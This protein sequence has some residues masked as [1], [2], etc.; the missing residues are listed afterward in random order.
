MFELCAVA[1]TIGAI[2]YRNLNMEMGTIALIA[3][4]SACFVALKIHTKRGAMFAVLL[5]SM[6]VLGALAVRHADRPISRDTFGQR[7][8]TAKILAVDRRLVQAN[9]IVRDKETGKRL[10]V[11]LRQRTTFLP[12]DTLHIHGLVE[13]PETFTTA[14]GRTF[15]YPRYLASKGIVGIGK[16][17]DAELLQ[18][19]RFSLARLAA[20]IRFRIADIFG[21]Y[22]S[23]PIDG[24]IAGMTV[25]Y[26]GGIPQSVQDLFRDTGVL[27]V[28]VLSGYNITML[29]GFLGLL[30]RGLS[31]RWRTAV[32]M[33]AII[34]LVVVSG[35]GVASVRA[36][37]MGSIALIAG[38]SI[39]RYQPFRALVLTYLLFFFL[40]PTMIFSDPGFHLSFLATAFMIVVLPKVELLFGWIPQTKV[41]NVR[42]LLMLAFSAPIFMLPYTMYF[43]GSFPLASP[44]A[45]IVL[46]IVTPICMLAAIAVLG[47]S[48]ITPLAHALGVALSLLGMVVLR[49]LT[50]SARLPVWNA[51]A[52]PWWAVLGVYGGTCGLLFRRELRQH[53]SRVRNSL[54]HASS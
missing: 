27:H 35:S 6:G 16:N 50:I 22:L 21:E 14:T 45:N 34:L 41:V 31:L 15:D 52:I 13:A 40:S 49:I 10:S 39:H 43:S 11:P 54:Q 18:E 2:L 9:L 25:G 26:Q 24:I 38:L 12:G 53:F 19:G 28:L 29:A 1:I 36:G 8:F 32:S 46:A 23:F 3:I 20:R 48:W 7:T 44:V 42:E 17:A 5:G 51:P 37:I 33:G 4:V 30:L 47:L